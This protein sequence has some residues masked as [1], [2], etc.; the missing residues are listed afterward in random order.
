VK[1]NQAEY[2]VRRMCGLLG[3]SPSGY[4]GWLHRPPSAR[5]LGDRVL[6]DRI[7]EAHRRSRGT[8]GVPRI[9]AELRAEG[10]RVGRKR[11]ARLMRNAGIC[12]VHRRKGVFTTKRDRS[13]APAPDLVNRDFTAEGPDR[14]WVADITYIPTWAGFLYLAVVLDV[15]SRRVVGWAMR[16]DLT[17]RLVLDALDMATSQRDAEGV[18]HHSDQGTQY[19]SIAFGLRCRDASVLPSMGSVG[20]CYDN[21]MAES[22]FATLETELLDRH[23]FRS[24]TQARVAVFDFI[25]GFYNPTRRHSSLGQISPLQYERRHLAT[26]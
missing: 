8:Y 7:V 6:R 3:V 23:T 14:L 1:G 24:R 18:V 4:Y 10:I 19:T 16:S 21:S 15:W 13:A 11:V 26:V 25:E 5:E 9:H 22:F 20:D 12:G 2:S 17:T